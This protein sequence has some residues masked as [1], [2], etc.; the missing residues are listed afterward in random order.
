MN[1]GMWS[2]LDEIAGPRG[3]EAAATSNG[4]TAFELLTTGEDGWPHAAWLGPAE[5]L[6]VNQESIALALWPKSA[7]RRNLDVSG[8]AVLQ[9]VAA[10]IVYNVRLSV[11]AVGAV[12]IRDTELAGFLGSV[13]AVTEDTVAYAEVLTGLTYRLHNSDE[14]LDRWRGQLDGL[15]IAVARH[16]QTSSEDNQL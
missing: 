12:A 1:G 4:L 8:R 11:E 6:P 14:V 3:V 9:I 13:V 10:G 2:A 15:I 7:T 5:I 16:R